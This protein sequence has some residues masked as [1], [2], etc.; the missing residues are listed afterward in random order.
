MK[1]LGSCRNFVTAIQAEGDGLTLCVSN[2]FNVMIVLIVMLPSN[3]L[4]LWRFLI[5]Q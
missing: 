1:S 5:Y 3:C 2:F 4:L